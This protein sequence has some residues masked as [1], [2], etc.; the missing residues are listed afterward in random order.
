MTTGPN[1]KGKSKEPTKVQNDGTDK[2]GN[3]KG[4][5]KVRLQEELFGATTDSFKFYGSSSPETETD[6]SDRDTENE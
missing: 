6:L 5:E 4:Q 3:P 1:A 2:T